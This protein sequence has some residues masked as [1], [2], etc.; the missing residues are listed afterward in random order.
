MP[1]QYFEQEVLRDKHTPQF[2]HQPV[3]VSKAMYQVEDNREEFFQ[4][5]YAT[6]FSQLSQVAMARQESAQHINQVGNTVHP[7]VLS[8][9]ERDEVTNR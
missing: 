5:L 6:H 8:D 3:L 2:A 1:Y 9:A 7:R 4:R